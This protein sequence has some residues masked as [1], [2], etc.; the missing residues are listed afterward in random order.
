MATVRKHLREL[1]FLDRYENSGFATLFDRNS[2]P[3]RAQ[4]E[5]ERRFGREKAWEAFQATD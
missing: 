2:R 1:R 5:F 3:D 4:T